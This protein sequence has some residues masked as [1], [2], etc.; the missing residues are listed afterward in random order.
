MILFCVGILLNERYPVE[1]SHVNTH[2]FWLEH[3]GG[4]EMIEQEKFIPQKID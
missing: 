1:N 2:T 3:L 4:N